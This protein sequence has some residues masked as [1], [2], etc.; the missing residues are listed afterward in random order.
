MKD[1]Y[2]N[3]NG[4]SLRILI[5]KYNLQVEREYTDKQAFEELVMITA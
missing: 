4:S 2:D 3:D 5:N 1:D